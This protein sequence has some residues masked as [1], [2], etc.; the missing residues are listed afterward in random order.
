MS[1]HAE[2]DHS[3]SIPA[4]LDAAPRATVVAS[5]KAELPLRKQLRRELRLRF[6]GE[7]DVLDLGGKKLVFLE[8][9]MLHWPEVIFAYSPTDRVLFPCDAFGQH[10][11]STER[12]DDELNPSFLMKEAAKRFRAPSSKA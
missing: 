10:V 9:P 4:V 11:A 2:I 5:T 7:G 3:G 6:A 1:L 8:A 12:F